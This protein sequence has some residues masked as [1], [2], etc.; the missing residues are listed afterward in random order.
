[1]KNR[2]AKKY[3]SLSDDDLN[4]SG[5]YLIAQKNIPAE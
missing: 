2:L 5:A 1:L 4:T 3:R